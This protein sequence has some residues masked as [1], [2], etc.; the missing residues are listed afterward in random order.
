L[1]PG[2]ALAARHGP[3]PADHAP[4]KT[5]PAAKDPPTTVTFA[6]TG[7]DLTITVPP[8]ADLGSGAPGSAIS[9]ALGTVTVTDGRALLKASWTVYAS[10]T[11]YTTGTGT[12]AETIS[13]ADASF[14][15]GTVTTSGTLA[16]SPTD[17]TTSGSPQTVVTGS[18]GSGSNTASWDPAIAVHLPAAAVVGSYTGTID[19]S[20]L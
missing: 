20:V 12:A 9:S 4:R 6:V 16:A 5:A 7:G 15:P 8:T 1:S 18:A 10:S 11:G 17:I 13:A 2:A 14:V 3:V 19:N